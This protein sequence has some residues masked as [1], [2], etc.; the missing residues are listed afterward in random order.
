[1]LDEAATRFAAVRGRPVRVELE[2]GRYP[3]AGMGL[4]VARVH[5]IKDTRG[6]EKGA[7]HRFVM[8]DAGFCDLL[9]KHPNAQRLTDP[10][11]VVRDSAGHLEARAVTD[12]FRYP[13]G[14]PK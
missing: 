4:L 11:T 2:P 10:F 5:D 8:V 12:E 3:V 9:A 7:G 14:P 1:M 13:P 6:N